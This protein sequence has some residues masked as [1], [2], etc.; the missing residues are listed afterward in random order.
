MTDWKVYFGAIITAIVASLCCIGPALFA[1]G[2]SF[3]PLGWVLSIEKFRPLFLVLAFLLLFLGYRRAFG[4][5]QCAC[6]PGSLLVRRLIFIGVAGVVFVLLAYPF[7]SLWI[8][9]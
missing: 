1:L 8:R 4:N 6:E 5:P 7:L 9:R 2:V 3:I